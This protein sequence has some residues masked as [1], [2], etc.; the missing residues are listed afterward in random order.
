MAKIYA[1]PTTIPMPEPDYKR[2]WDEVI[3]A[4]N[5]WIEKI[6]DWCKRQ[7][8]N[9]QYLGE[10]VS[11]GVADGAARYLVCGT[12]PFALMHLPVGD[13]WRGGAAWERGVNLSDVKKQ[14]A[15]REMWK[16]KG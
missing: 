10:E 12:K 8:G 3:A 2:P 11:V 5:A 6:R 16:K 9:K 13:A 15:F 14:M 7:S 4:E 1:T